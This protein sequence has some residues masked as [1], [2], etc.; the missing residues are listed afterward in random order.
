MGRNG[1]GTSVGVF[2]GGVGYDPRV[3]GNGYRYSCEGI[4]VGAGHGY[5]LSVRQILI[6]LFNSAVSGMVS[7]SFI[8]SRFILSSHFQF[9]IIL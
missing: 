6:A 5:H 9:S 1:Y 3:G 7:W 4:W 2:C 8:K